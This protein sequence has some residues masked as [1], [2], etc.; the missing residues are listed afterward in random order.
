MH[1]MINSRGAGRKGGRE[2]FGVLGFFFYDRALE[3]GNGN[4]ESARAKKKKQRSL[5]IYKGNI[6]KKMGV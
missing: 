2:K 5:R 6:Y 1:F 3:I 4:L